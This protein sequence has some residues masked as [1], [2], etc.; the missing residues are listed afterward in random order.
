[1][2]NGIMLHAARHSPTIGDHMPS[3]DTVQSLLGGPSGL[4]SPPKTLARI[5]KRG[6]RANGPRLAVARARDQSDRRTSQRIREVERNETAPLVAENTLPATAGTL[7][8]I[9]LFGLM[10]LGGA[11]SLREVARRLQ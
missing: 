5:A 7:P 11:F 4:N 10:A 2:P 3:S 1:M 6:F 9:A 8:L